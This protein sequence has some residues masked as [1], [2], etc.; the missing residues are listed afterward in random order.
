MLH[1]VSSWKCGACLYVSAI[2][3]SSHIAHGGHSY[4]GGAI[5][6]ILK[7][8]EA[9]REGCVALSSFMEVISSTYD[10]VVLRHALQ[11]APPC[12]RSA[13]AEMKE[14]FLVCMVSRGKYS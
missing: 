1:L 13:P 2:Y 6:G 12:C 11:D 3:A 14:A 7:R 10:P 8:Y 4:T 9:D 5:C